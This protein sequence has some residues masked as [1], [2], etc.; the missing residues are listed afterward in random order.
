MI[1]FGYVRFG[2]A[3]CAALGLHAL[4]YLSLGSLYPIQQVVQRSS[5]LEVSILPQKTTAKPLKSLKPEQVVQPRIQQQALLQTNKAEIPEAKVS[6]RVK[7]TSEEVA[8]EENTEP[9]TVLVPQHIQTLILAKVSYPRRARRHGWEG[10]AELSFQ[11]N[12]Q[13]VQEINMLVSTGFDVL[14]QAAWQA[15][16]SIA[17]LPL[18]DG[19]Y[20]LPVVFRIQ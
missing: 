13:K 14:D 7:E 8:Y 5:P 4:I 19:K 16:V 6:Q 20:R 1:N 2:V 11:I 10:E 12:Q 15:L 17:S 3:L 18:N 9:E